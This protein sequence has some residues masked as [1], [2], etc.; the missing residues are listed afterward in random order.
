MKAMPDRPRLWGIMHR[1]TD[2]YKG[3]TDDTIQRLLYRRQF[4]LGS[5]FVDGLP[6]WQRMKIGLRL[7]LTV[8]PDLPLLHVAHGHNHL[9]VL[10]F[11]L[12]PSIPTDSNASVVER[13]LAHL[14]TDP[15]L[16][17]F[18]ERT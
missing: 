3:A 11:V 17:T 5:K 15:N 7:L 14:E 12:D 16:D 18:L 9:T 8:H 6:N 1:N 10:G 13:L 2:I 4:V